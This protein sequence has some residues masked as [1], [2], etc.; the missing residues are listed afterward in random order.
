MATTT[1]TETGASFDLQLT[2]SQ[3]LVQRTARE[4]A[5]EKLLPIAHDFDEQ[6]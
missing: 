3:A 2:D 1:S 6:G 4:F 5:R